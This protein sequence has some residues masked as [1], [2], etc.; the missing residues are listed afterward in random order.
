M[1][2]PFDVYQHLKQKTAMLRFN[3]AVFCF[4]GRESDGLFYPDGEAIDCS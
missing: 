2:A 1:N 4:E 3:M